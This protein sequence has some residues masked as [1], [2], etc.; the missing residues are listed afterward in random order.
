MIKLV[1]AEFFFSHAEKKRCLN[2]GHLSKDVTNMLN[3]MYQAAIDM[4]LSSIDHESDI[5]L[6]ARLGDVS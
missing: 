5:E 6:E 4:N 1:T 3:L 2:K